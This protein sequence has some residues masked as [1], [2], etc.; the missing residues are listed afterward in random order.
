MTTVTVNFLML[1]RPA[2][3][4]AVQVT[5]V[6]PTGNIEP[7]VGRHVVCTV[8]STASVAGTANVTRALEASVASVV[9]SVGTVIDGGLSLTVT[10]NLFLARLP[11]LAEVQ[12][13]VVVWR[14]N[15][16][17]ERGL[18]ST[19]TERPEGPATAEAV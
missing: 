5:V 14:A 6:V 18:Q 1:R 12:V 9:T 8:P 7:E 3:S 19:G 17:P 13:T 15:N 10:S 2:L 11:A 4:A 16:A